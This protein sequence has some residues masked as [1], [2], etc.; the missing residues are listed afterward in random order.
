MFLCRNLK[1]FVSL[2]GFSPQCS[3]CELFLLF[4]SRVNTPHS[5]FYLITLFKFKVG[6]LVHT[7]LICTKSIYDQLQIYM[8][9]FLTYKS[10]YKKNIYVF[11][12]IKNLIFGDSNFHYFE[13]YD[14]YPRFST[15][16]LSCNP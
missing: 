10:F 11:R 2:N 8:L 5:P 12:Q 1:I 4:K 6:G 9:I 13:K 16:E 7:I 14:I 3:Y 15:K